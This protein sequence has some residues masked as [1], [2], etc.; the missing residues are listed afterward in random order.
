MKALP[1]FEM[2]EMI[3]GRKVGKEYFSDLKFDSGLLLQQNC[4]IY[5]FISCA[6]GNE[7]STLIHFLCA[8]LVTLPASCVTKN[9]ESP[10]L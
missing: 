3:Q 8:L 2:V 7:P 1:L 5:L 10:S 4:K 9:M 6:F